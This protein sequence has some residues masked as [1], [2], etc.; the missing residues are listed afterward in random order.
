[1]ARRCGR[2][3]VGRTHGAASARNH[4]RWASCP[5]WE[6]R[7]GVGRRIEALRPYWDHLVRDVRVGPLDVRIRLADF[8]P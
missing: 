7:R 6:P 5:A 1:M 8:D 2:R 3:Q 4:G